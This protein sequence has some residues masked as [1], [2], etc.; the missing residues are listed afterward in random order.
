MA[1]VILYSR[2]PVQRFVDVG[3]G[4]GYFL[5]AVRKYLPSNAHRFYGIE[6][7]PPPVPERSTHPNYLVGEV[8]DLPG[9]FDGG[10]C[11]EV[12]EHL[13][14]RMMRSLLEQIAHKSNPGACYIVN[15]GLSDFVMTVRPDYLDPVRR[16]HIVSWSLPAVS[17]LCAGLPLTVHKITGKPWAFVLE[18]QRSTDNSRSST[19]EDIRLRAS[20]SLSENKALLTDPVMGTVMLVLG[21]YTVLAFP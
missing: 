15:T 3:T 12:V 5:D 13:T 2:I 7:F 4:P 18:R 6:K 19:E 1:E 16:G 21:H 14:P 11:M 20:T 17:A 8:N 9:T 10:L